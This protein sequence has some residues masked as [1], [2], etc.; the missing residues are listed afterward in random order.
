[1]VSTEALCN[2]HHFPSVDGETGDVTRY[3]EVVE[4]IIR[5]LP[6]DVI[7]VPGHADD[8]DM[9]GFRSFHEMLTKTR[10]IVRAGVAEG[11]T[12]VQL[13]KG[14]VLAGFASY[15]SYMGRND[16]LDTL[17]DGLTTTRVE[18]GDL[19]GPMGSSTRP[20]RRRGR[21]R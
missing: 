16:W 13:K 4:R 14:D 6:D 19:P 10:D 17:H 21:T 18:R 3:P 9:A 2:C 8:C 12:L 7:L 1:M 20:R 11:K 5:T 15:E